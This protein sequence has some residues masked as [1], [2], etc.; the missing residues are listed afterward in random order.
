MSWSD[1]GGVVALLPGEKRRFWSS[2][3]PRSMQLVEA[4]RTGPGRNSGSGLPF[5]R[6]RW[7]QAVMSAPCSRSHVSVGRAATDA[8]VVGDDALALRGPRDRD[9][10]VDPDEDVLALDLAEVLEERDAADHGSSLTPR[11]SG[12]RGRRGGWSSPTRC[13]TS[14]APWRACRLVDGDRHRERRVEGA[15]RPGCRR[16]R[17][18]RSVLV[19]HEDPCE[20]LGLGGGL[21]G[22][23]DLVGG[24][25]RRPG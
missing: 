15:T 5:G 9:V 3:H 22:L 19:V 16:C 1:E 8:E 25:P 11:R 23:V 20:A 14:R 6:P 12:G 7:V 18:R 2:V 24:R 13:R 17:S 4:C 10:E 21:E